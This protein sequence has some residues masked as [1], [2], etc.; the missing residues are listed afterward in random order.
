MILDGH[1]QFSNSQSLTA[2]AAS[3]NVIDL[4]ID[5]NIG[6]GEQL[7]VVLNV[8]VASDFTTGDETYSIAVQADDN[9][10][11][12]SAATVGTF[13]IVG[14]VAAGTKYVFILPADLTT[15]RF[16]RLNYTLAGTTPSVTLS[17][18]LMPA[19]NGI[20]N[21]VNY[22]SGFTVS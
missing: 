14:A 1:L 11:F 18:H 10:S 9:A 19:N 20:D 4:G 16:L 8:E 6:I 17:A 7:A 13:T 5:R 15:E 22:T 21:S 12:S 2:T 3:T